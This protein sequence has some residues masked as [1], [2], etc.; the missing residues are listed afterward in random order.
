[1]ND[2]TIIHSAACRRCWQPAPSRYRG[3]AGRAGHDAHVHGSSRWWSDGS[4]M[5]QGWPR[6]AWPPTLDSP[7][8]DESHRQR[9]ELIGRLQERCYSL[10]AIRDLCAASASGRSLDDVLGGS[11]SVL[12]DQG[13]LSPRPTSW[14]KQYRRWSARAS[15][16]QRS[17]PGSSTAEIPTLRRGTCEHPHCCR[18]SVTRSVPESNRSRPSAWPPGW[19]PVRRSRPARSPTWL[20]AN[21]GHEDVPVVA[22]LVSVGRRASEEATPTSRCVGV[23]EVCLARAARTLYGASPRFWVPLP[24]LV[25]AARKAS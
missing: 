9:L 8:Y 18:S 25:A 11:A 20:W 21:F 24:G 17:T 6:F 22:E 5:S 15:G 13:A 14:S 3:L 19:P 1:M 2:R 23:P 12:I 16:R 4:S 10:A 7:R